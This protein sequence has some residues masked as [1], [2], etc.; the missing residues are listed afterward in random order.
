M[1]RLVCFGCDVGCYVCGEMYYVCVVLVLWFVGG[2]IVCVGENICGFVDVF[3]R[4]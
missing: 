4:W 3:E 1:G 2:G